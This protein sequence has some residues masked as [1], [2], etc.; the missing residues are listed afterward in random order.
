MM[1]KV[2]ASRVVSNTFPKSSFAAFSPSAAIGRPLWFAS[3]RPDAA[4]VALYLVLPR[5]AHLA[6]GVR[7][8]HAS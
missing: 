3:W 7:E 6:P 4:A 8:L 5:A 2:G 1:R